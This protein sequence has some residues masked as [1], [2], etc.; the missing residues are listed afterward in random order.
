MPTFYVDNI[1]FNRDHFLKYMKYKGIN[2]RPVFYP[3]HNFKFYK[4]KSYKNQFPISYRISK[5]GVNLPSYLDLEQKE[6]DKI[7]KYIQRYFLKNKLI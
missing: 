5:F 7:I 6:L 1:N 2:L 4:F 3:L